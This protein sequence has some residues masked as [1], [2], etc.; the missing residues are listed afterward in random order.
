M[1]ITQVTPTTTAAE[2]SD[3]SCS[4]PV[5]LRS[6]L[7][8]VRRHSLIYMVG[9]AFSN[10]IGFILIPVYTHY[11]DRAH[12]G[13]MSLVD[14]VMSVMMMILSL[15]IS[16]GLTRFFY[17]TT[18][19]LQRRRLVS[20]A[21]FGPGLI[22]FPIVMA[23]MF[24]SG[25]VCRLLG[26]DV[27]YKTY[28]G[29]S[30]AA[31]WFSMWAEIGY[32]Y[33]RICYMSKTFVALTSLQIAASLSLNLYF[34]TRLG[35]GIWGICYS[36]LI[37]QALVGTSLAVLIMAETRCLPRMTELRRLLGFSIH[38]VPSTVALQMT[39][40]LN[41]ILLRWLLTG[42]STLV[43]A[44]VGL[45]SAGQKLGVVVNR[46]VTVPFQAF[47]RPRRMELAV[48]DTPDMRRILARMCTYATLVTCQFALWISVGA[49][50]VLKLLCDEDYWDAHRVVPLIAASYV[51]LGLEHH[52]ATGMHF[53]RRTHWATAIGAF[54]LFTLIVADIVLVPRYGMVAAAVA[55]LLS[56]SLRSSLFLAVSHHYHPIPFELRRL[57]LAGLLALAVYGLAVQLCTF[58]SVWAT[59]A[60]RL[61]VASSYLPVLRVTAC[62]QPIE[63][64]V[65]LS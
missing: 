11:I 24:A 48:Q 27:S 52:F 38:L 36:T 19:E 35:W 32:A 30:L 59:L 5:T 40:Y 58:D 55:T 62:W 57:T 21:V 10:A 3:T 22:T 47:W 12:Y 49:A 51:V 42:S 6:E 60:C 18:D 26:I 61:L 37:V 25:A 28:F 14:V 16:D 7:Q 17:T 2:T 50:P 15:G 65:T 29:I 43:L 20:S 54:A 56:T 23:T 1:S 53:A 45:Y 8:S 33:L 46:F 34:V 13:V 64:E 39:N 63:N 41:L 9:P 44:Q 31:A 4:A